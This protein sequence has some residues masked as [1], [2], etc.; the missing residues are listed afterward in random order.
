MAITLER[1]M[2][3]NAK[4]IASANKFRVPMERAVA[5]RP[6]T[7]FTNSLRPLPERR[8]ATLAVQR[9]FSLESLTA[10]AQVF[11]PHGQPAYR[12]PPVLG[13]MPTASVPAIRATQTSQ[14]LVV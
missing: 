14:Y 1:L 5:Q 13:V 2:M 4:R 3:A 10:Q 12:L 7:E 6:A 9:R 8:V 11:R